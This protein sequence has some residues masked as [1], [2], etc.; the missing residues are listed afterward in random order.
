MYKNKKQLT[1]FY[2]GSRICYIIYENFA[3][4]KNFSGSRLCW[5][6]G[7]TVLLPGWVIWKYWDCPWK[8]FSLGSWL[9]S[10]LSTPN[11]G[12]G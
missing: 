10:A 1:G 8:F 6:R 11:G 9:V 4:Y 3:I 12:E 7:V 5:Y 2:A